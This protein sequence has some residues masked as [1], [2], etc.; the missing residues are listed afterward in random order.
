M[1][2]RKRREK[3][4]LRC[5]GTDNRCEAFVLRI[6]RKR[7]FFISE[8][9]EKLEYRADMCYNSVEWNGLQI[10]IKPVL[11]KL[12]NAGLKTA[13]IARFYSAHGSVIYCG[14]SVYRILPKTFKERFCGI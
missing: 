4:G 11:P 8:S 14:T 10:T 5:F 7:T 6:F 9:S 1:T 2:D 13:R 3:K 12:A